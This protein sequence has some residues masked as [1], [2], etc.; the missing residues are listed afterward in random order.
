MFFR[1]DDIPWENTWAIDIGQ[2]VYSHFTY[3]ET[4]FNIV[5][6]R[7]LGLSYPDMWRYL[8]DTFHATIHSKDGIYCYAT[9]DNYEDCRKACDLLNSRWTEILSYID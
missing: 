8:R 3:C 7:I 1:P 5:L 2:G 6:A 4:S 9:F